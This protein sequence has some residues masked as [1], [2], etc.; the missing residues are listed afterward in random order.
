MK[1]IIELLKSLKDSSP[2]TIDQQKIA[3]QSLSEKAHLCIYQ[4]SISYANGK[5]F[6]LGRDSRK[7]KLIQVDTDGQPA[8]M[9]ADHQA[10]DLVRE[11]F[12][13]AV[14]RTFGLSTS[15]G[16]GD[17]LGLAT[18]GHLQAVEGTGCVPF[19]AQQSIREMTRTQRTPQQ[20]MDDAMWGVFQTG[21]REGFG[22]DA[23][24][25][26]TPEDIDRC[27]AVGFTMYTF[28]PGDH[29]RSDADTMDKTSLQRAFEGMNWGDLETSL[30]DIRSIYLGK[31]FPLDQGPSISLDEETLFRAMV[32]YGGAI[33]H[34]VR[35]YRHLTEK[36]GSHPFEVEISVDETD[37]PTTV[38]EHY[39][40]S[41]ELKRLGVQWVSLAP[42]FIGAFEK[43]IDYKGDLSAFRESF[44]AHA[45]VARTLGPYK[46]SLHSGSD[47]FSVYPIA[48]E[49]TDG[50]VHLKTAGT[51]YL[52]ALRVVARK[53]PDLFRRILDFAFTRFD[54]DR[55]SYHISAQ[56]ETVP[57][58]SELDDSQLE[59][60]L[61]INDGRQLLHVTYGSVLTAQNEQGNYLFRDELLDVLIDN[62]EEH[63]AILADHMKKH[64]QP[65]AR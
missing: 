29:V 64:I 61:D 48:A 31:S 6:A 24:H 49:L 45:A 4:P 17:R 5:L 65:F 43:G 7:L 36:C 42:R 44:A 11:N 63:F 28:D 52:E 47:K 10:A 9:E 30:S 51:S 59:V 34:S 18:P 12:P 41:A 39:L 58:S 32:K 50:L 21:W 3:A 8:V 35:M 60:V 14:P 20:V 56:I 22:S 62:E 15:I 38:A 19:V 23:D 25:L 26:K 53:S 1:I 2:L 13:W 40:V 55:A 16:L 37:T 46:L 57:P 27:L 54:E 33:A